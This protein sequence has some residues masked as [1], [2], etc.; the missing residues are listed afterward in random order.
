MIGDCFEASGRWITEHFDDDAKLVH[1]EVSGQKA[2]KGIRYCHGWIERGDVVID[3]AN[4][5]INEYPKELYYAIA[6][7]VDQPGTI[8]K[9]D[10]QQALKMML[11]EEHYGPWE[12]VCEL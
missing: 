5:T 10:R 1:A 6:D 9:Y 3:V 2:L 8:A 4:G 7:V 12:L 11:R